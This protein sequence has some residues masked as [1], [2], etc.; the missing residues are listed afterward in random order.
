MKTK[1]IFITLAIIVLGITTY[2]GLHYAK[3][4]VYQHN[5]ISILIDVTDVQKYPITASAVTS[6]VGINERKWWSYTARVQTLSNYNYT[7]IAKVELTDA[8]VAFSNPNKRTKQIAG[9]TEALNRQL[10]SVYQSGSGREHSALYEPIIRE[11]NR[12]SNLKGKRIMIIQSDLQE[13]SELFS[14][15]R[16][17]DY[18][19]LQHQSEAVINKLTKYLQPQNLQGIDIYIVYEPKDENDNKR[20]LMMVHVFQKILESHNATVHISANIITP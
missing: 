11:A 4:Q 10:D 3:N 9:F 6:L 16:N 7:A 17:V 13:H 2:I 5:E 18:A 8:F 14:V 20:F 1:L 19:L 12:F 15:Y